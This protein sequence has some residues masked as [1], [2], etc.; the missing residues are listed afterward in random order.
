[1]WIAIG[2]M[3]LFLFGRPRWHEQFVTAALTVCPLLVAAKM[4]FD[5]R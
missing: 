2:A 5:A 3:V 4:G 1:M